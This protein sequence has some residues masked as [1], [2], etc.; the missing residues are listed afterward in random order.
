MGHIVMV[1]CWMGCLDI[2]ERSV[3]L[4]LM[5]NIEHINGTTAGILIYQLAFNTINPWYICIIQTMASSGISIYG[6]MRIIHKP[7]VGLKTIILENKTH[8]VN[9]LFMRLIFF[10]LV[11]FIVNLFRTNV[12]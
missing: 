4:T 10:G 9:Y 12:I 7:D 1:R 6:V 3:N 2:E 8:I 5:S 11:Y